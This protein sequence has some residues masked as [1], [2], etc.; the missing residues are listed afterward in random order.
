MAILLIA[1]L[2]TG[3][4]SVATAEQ[5]SSAPEET[6]LA[7]VA[8]MEVV[9]ENAKE[10]IVYEG[11]A[12]TYYFDVAYAE[13]IGRY[14]TALTEQWDES[15]YF[16]NGLSALPVYYYKGTPWTMWVLASWIWTMMAIGK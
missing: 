13:Q 14:Y 1:G 8:A 5:P 3:C 9:V 2:L 10:D 12:S 6:T 11:D 15:K 7:T 16:E 4:N